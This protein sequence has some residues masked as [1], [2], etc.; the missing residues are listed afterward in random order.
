[1]SWS[2]HPWWCPGRRDQR[3][4][5]PGTRRATLT[6]VAC[7]IIGAWPPTNSPPA[8]A[9]GAT[10]CSP[11]TPGCRPAAAPRAGPAARGGRAARRPV[12]RLPRAAR[13]G[14]R[15]R[16]VAV[17]ARAAGPRA[18][19]DR[20]RARAPVPRRRPRRARA[21]AHEPPPHAVG[22]S[23]FSTG[24]PTCRCM[25]FDAA[26]QIVAA[27]P[28]ARRCSATTPLPGAR[29]Q[30][31]LARTSRARSRRASSNTA[32]AGRRIEEEVVADLTTAGAR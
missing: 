10:G 15:A 28:L 6:R 7:A 3:T 8:C 24:S 23:A 17:G 13:A 1:M 29:A 11:P 9:P 30:R 32:G 20:R 22:S 2:W 5:Q 31:P 14:P 27:N 4:A 25:V 16:P 12:G 19:A 26:W 21:P 18:A